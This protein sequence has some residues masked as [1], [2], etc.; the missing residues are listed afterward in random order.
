VVGPSFTFVL[1]CL[2]KL[3]QPSRSDQAHLSSPPF[4]FDLRFASLQDLGNTNYSIL[5]P[6][7]MF[8]RR[9]NAEL[10]ARALNSLGVDAKVNERNDITLD[11]FKMSPSSSFSLPQSQ[12]YL[13]LAVNSLFYISGSAYK[14]NNRRAY[15]HG[16]ML[17]SAQLAQLG[18]SLKSLRVS[19]P[20]LPSLYFYHFH[21]LSCSPR[22]VLFR[23]GIHHQQSN[24]LRSLSRPKHHHSPPYSQP[25]SIRRSRHRRVHKGVRG[26]GEGS[27]GGEGGGVVGGGR[28]EGGG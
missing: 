18:N 4:P 23:A 28:G 13:G 2:P 16:T 12:A 20:S 14:L 21:S 27:E 19:T 9:P 1:P 17:I 5:I 22:R 7:V 3:T 24:R 10:V 15:H 8:E 6:K 26:W 11:G 25:R